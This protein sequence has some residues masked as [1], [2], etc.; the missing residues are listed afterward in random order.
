MR[1][2]NYY[3]QGKRWWPRLH[4]KGG[5]HEIYHRQCVFR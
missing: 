3:Q 2:E 4:E 5:K 1:V